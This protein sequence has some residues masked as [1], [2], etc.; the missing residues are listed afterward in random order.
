MHP[1]IVDRIEL[2]VHRAPGAPPLI[3]PRLRPTR[4]ELHRGILLGEE[5]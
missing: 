3:G 5:R 1:V 2:A 4:P